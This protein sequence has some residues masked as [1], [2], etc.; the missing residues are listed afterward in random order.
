MPSNA[1]QTGALSLP[2]AAGGANAGLRD[3]LLDGL[4]DYFAF[5]L[6]AD[7]NA[8]LASMAGQTHAVLPGPPAGRFPFNPER[9]FVRQSIPALYMWRDE[10]PDGIRYEQ[11][12]VLRTRRVSLVH[13]LYIFSEQTI[14]TGGV[15]QSGLRNAVD[16]SLRAATEYGHRNDY[17]HH[18]AP[19]GTPIQTPLKLD[20]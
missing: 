12:T 17:G 6:A 13:G 16:A 15:V 8:K 20:G 14:P 5:W 1:S 2:L 18:G 10:G 7:L 4:L 3:P 19:L 11:Y 9:T